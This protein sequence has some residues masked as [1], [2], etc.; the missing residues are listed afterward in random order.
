MPGKI[1][2]TRNVSP[3][4]DQRLKPLFID[5]HLLHHLPVYAKT[6]LDFN[7]FFRFAQKFI[8]FDDLAGDRRRGDDI[9]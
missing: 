3:P 8:W 2:W 1:Q 9:R 6:Q 5:S 4:I 7:Q